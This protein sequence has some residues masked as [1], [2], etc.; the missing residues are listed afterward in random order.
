LLVVIAIIALLIGILLPALGRAR[1]SARSLV[2]QTNERQLGQSLTIYANDNKN[3]FPPNH[4]DPDNPDDPART[5]RRWFDFDVIGTI[6]ESQDFGDIA[7][8]DPTDISGR[9]PTVGGSVMLCPTHPQGGRS[10]SM[11]YWASSYVKVRR[12]GSFGP[13]GFFVTDRPGQVP[14][15]TNSELG[16][17]FKSDVEFASNVLLVADAWGNFLKDSDGKGTRGYT[18]ETI[19]AQLLPGERFGIAGETEITDLFGNW[20][21]DGSLEL[22]SSTAVVRSYIPYYRHPRRNSQ[23]QALEGKA[24]F[25]FADGSARSFNYN[26]L[27]D[28]EDSS[29]PRSSYNVLWTPLDNRI[30]N[31]LLGNR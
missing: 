16:R 2:C 17:G 14:G 15:A 4:N 21:T 10:Y 18:Q 26:D 29:A 27:V 6:I 25:A 24:Q 20:R 13:G 30:E 1:D 9:A 5:G 3:L 11:N 28:L 22:D 31:Q 23:F 8:Q 7:F 12:A 19:G